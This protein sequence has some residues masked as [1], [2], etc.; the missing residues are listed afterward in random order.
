MNPVV[1]IPTFIYPRRHRGGADVVSTYDHPTAPNQ[2]GE[3]GRCLESLAKVEGL[4]LVVILVS[5]D[6]SLEVQAAEKVQAIANRHPDVTTLVIGAAELAL[7]EQR[8]A[9]QNIE[10]LSKEIGL[11]GYG[12]IRNLGL[13]VANVLGFDAVVFLD[14]D[15]V[16]D[17]PK[18]LE[19]A[20]YG[21]GKL[22][23]QGVPIVAKTG[24]YLNDQDSY[25]SKWEDKWYNRFWQ[26]GRAFNEWITKAMRGPRLSRSNHVCGGCLAVHKEAFRRLAFDPWITRG[27]DL[28]YMLDLRMYGSDIWFDNQWV[29]RHL[30]PRTA[31][32]GTRFR[33][34]IFRWLYEYRKL[35]YSRA[36]ID[37]QQV[38]PASLEPYPGP[39]LEPGPSAPH[40][41]YGMDAQLRTPRQEGLPPGRQGRHGCGFGLRRGQLREVLRVPVRLARGHESSGKRPAA[42]RGPGALGHAARPG[43]GGRGPGPGS[44]GRERLDGRPGCRG[45]RGGGRRRRGC[46]CDSCGSP[47]PARAPRPPRAFRRP[48][49]CRARTSTPA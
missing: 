21:L 37:L 13:L 36:L 26:Q 48:G 14:D 11:Q 6:V 7:I 35:E 42:L 43:C 16:V 25:L 24:Y 32:E 15:E 45:R 8:M 30:P 34:D 38:K 10:R 49:P 3:L 31:S 17:D 12:A 23:R 18:F 47:R 41:A 22:T 9:Q 28:D 33:Q 39:F 29:L 19:K 4:G 27:E 2:E 20:M 1:V 5:A 40:S 44:G 46:W